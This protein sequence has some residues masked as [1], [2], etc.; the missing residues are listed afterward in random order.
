[1]KAKKNMI[2]VFYE[3]YYHLSDLHI[4]YHPNKHA[5]SNV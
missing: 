3:K 4:I 1:M 2:L 5:F